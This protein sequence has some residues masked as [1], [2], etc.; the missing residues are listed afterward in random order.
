MGLSRL[1]TLPAAIGRG[2]VTHREG[3][4]NCSLHKY[5]KDRDDAMLTLSCFLS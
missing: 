2:S 5:R 3:I 4:E 1:R